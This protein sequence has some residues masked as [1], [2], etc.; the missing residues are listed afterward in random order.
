MVACVAD[1]L[2]YKWFSRVRGPAA[3]QANGWTNL[4]KIERDC[5]CDFNSKTF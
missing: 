1:A 4:K 3:T 5:N 2:N